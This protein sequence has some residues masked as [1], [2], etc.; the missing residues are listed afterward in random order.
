M[1]TEPIGLAR[2]LPAQRVMRAVIGDTDMA[3]WR[4]R[5]GKL[6]AWGNRC[7]H[8]GMRLSHGFVRGDALACLYHGWHYGSSG[9]CTYIPAHPDLVPPKTIKTESYRI[10]EQSGILWVSSDGDVSAPSLPGNLV[11]VRSLTLDCSRGTAIHGFMTVAMPARGAAP[12]SGH[13]SPDHPNV[14]VYG[15]ADRVVVVLQQNPAHSVTAHI[16]AGDALSVDDLIALSRWCEAVRRSA[17]KPVDPKG[18]G[19]STKPEA[20]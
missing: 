7:P 4:G 11:P 14:I 15:G 8:R 18:A 17:E 1:T 5:S 16:L 10:A 3:I 6:A 13:V 19:Q 12:A 2:D 20:T 9:R